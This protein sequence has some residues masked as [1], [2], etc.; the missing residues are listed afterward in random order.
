MGKKEST[1]CKGARSVGELS[2]VM[3][4]FYF[5][6]LNSMWITP[7][8]A[9]VRASQVA[10]VVKNLPANAGDL[11]SIPGLGRSPGEGDGSPLQYPCL[12]SPMDGE[13]W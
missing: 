4:I 8:Y 10:L 9:F 11:G 2:R 12:E 7:V 13:A 3:E 1:G 5:L 6:V